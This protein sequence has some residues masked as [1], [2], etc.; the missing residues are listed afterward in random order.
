MFLN[1]AFFKKKITFTVHEF[2]KKK[3]PPVSLKKFLYKCLITVKIYMLKGTSLLI[4]CCI[5][6]LEVNLKSLR[7]FST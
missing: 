6:Y 5:L 2:I 1:E 3:R 7:R 4:K